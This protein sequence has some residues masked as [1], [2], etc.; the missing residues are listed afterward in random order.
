MNAPDML[1]IIN[2]PEDGTEFPISRAP[3]IVGM[4]NTCDVSVH[5]DED[6]ES[7]HARLSAVSDGYRVRK[8]RGGRLT[9][10]GKRAGLFRSRI[11]REGDVLEVG[12]TEFSLQCAPD[13]LAKRSRGLTGENDFVWFLRSMGMRFLGLFIPRRSRDRRRSGGLFRWMVILFIIAVVAGYFWPNLARYLQYYAVYYG[14]MAIDQVMELT[15]GP[16]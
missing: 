5:L 12:N 9:I 6:I 4:D 7:F 10:N 13:G 11:L 1:E 15:K 8:I 2:G 3:I 16:A 14:R